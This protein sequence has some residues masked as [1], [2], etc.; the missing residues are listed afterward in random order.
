MWRSFF[1]LDVSDTR[2]DSGAWQ[3]MP[4]AS[5]SETRFPEYSVDGFMF[6]LTSRTKRVKTEGGKYA[7]AV[8]KGRASV[9]F[10]DDDYRPKNQYRRFTNDCLVIRFPGFAYM[11]SLHYSPSQI[12]IVAH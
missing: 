7:R 9:D 8:N 4:L 1:F 3:T 11:P 12:N 10:I 5:T 6:L 2:A